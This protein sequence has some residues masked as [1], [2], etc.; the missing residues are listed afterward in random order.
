MRHLLIFIMCVLLSLSSPVSGESWIISGKGT[1]A[2]ASAIN[3]GIYTFQSGNNNWADIQGTNGGPIESGTAGLVSSDAGKVNIAK[4][5][6]FTNTQIG[7]WIYVNFATYQDGRYEVISRS[8]DDITIEMVFGIA[9]APTN[10]FRVGGAL[11]NPGD[12][13]QAQSASERILEAGD[14]VWIADNGDYT[15]V[16]ASDSILYITVPGIGP[17][18]IIWEG[19]VADVTGVPEKGDFGIVTFD[20]T[21]ITNCIETAIGGSVHHTFIGLNLENATDDGLNGNT[22][23]DSNITAIRCRFSLNGGW[24]MQGNNNI[25][26]IFCDFDTN[27]GGGLDGDSP[28]NPIGCVFRNNTG[29]GVVGGPLTVIG[30]L[31]SE[32][33]TKGIWSEAGGLTAWGNTIDMNNQAGAQGIRQDSGNIAL[34]IAMNNVFTDCVTGIQDDASLGQNAILGYN[35]Y[36]SNTT[37]H[38]NANVIPQPVDGDNSGNLVKDEL[39][40]VLWTVDDQTY[41]LQSAFKESGVDASYTKAY[42][43]DFNGGAGDNPPDPLTGLSF[44]DNGAQQRVEAGTG[45]GEG[46]W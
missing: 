38:A 40:S 19:H 1:G 27:S 8:D 32:N 23:T 18:P 17:N 20:A 29:S 44:M 26:A 43:D 21:G 14:K 35:L 33:T 42:W 36:N 7:N 25:R 31:F 22:V 41:I 11:P 24:G 12:I 2:D 34:W 10:V 45:D 5:G 4:T 15:T 39:E 28:V 46:W 6:A 37:A 30:C 3:A 13:P 16:D 9:E